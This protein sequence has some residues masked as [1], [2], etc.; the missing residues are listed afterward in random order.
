MET[1][2]P[3][4]E[5]IAVYGSLMQ[6]HGA[7][8]LA[9]TVD[10][11]KLVGKCKIPGLLYD[12]GEFPG[13]VPGDSEVMG[14]LYEVKHPDALRLLDDYEAFYPNDPKLSL[15]VRQRM[16][17]VEPKIE[18]WGYLYNQTLSGMPRVEGGN[19]TEYLRQQNRPLKVGPVT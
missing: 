8:A 16:Q 10:K 11:L 12:L 5:Y 7:Q 18:C 9:G 1:V 13:L 19:W 17:L 3:E 4:R 2:N 6:I 15:F 14:E